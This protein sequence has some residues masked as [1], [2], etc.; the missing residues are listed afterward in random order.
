VLQSKVDGIT[1]F[2]EEEFDSIKWLSLR[3]VLAEPRNTL[4]PHMHRFTRKLM[5]VIA[6]A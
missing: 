5:N 1:S 2:D 4:D 6:C 3:Q